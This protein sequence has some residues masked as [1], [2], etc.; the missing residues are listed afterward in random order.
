MRQPAACNA[1]DRP[2]RRQP[3]RVHQQKHGRVQRRR[4]ASTSG[5]STA[6]GVQLRVR[7]C[8]RQRRRCLLRRRRRPRA[9][10]RDSRLLARCCAHACI[11]CRQQ[12]HAAAVRRA[13]GRVRHRKRCCPLRP[14]G[15]EAS[16]HTFGPRTRGTAPT[17]TARAASAAAAGGERTHPR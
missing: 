15:H 1:A 11:D 13:P 17:Q 4:H 5:K 9:V 12:L 7:A 2:A 8:A 3:R 16:L 10:Q 14:R 6:S